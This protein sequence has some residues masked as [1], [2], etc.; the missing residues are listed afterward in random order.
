MRR[1]R[2]AAD[3]PPAERPRIEVMDEHGEAFAALVERV[4]HEKGADFSICDIEVPIRPA[5]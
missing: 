2:V 5:P 4:R 1:V 3:L